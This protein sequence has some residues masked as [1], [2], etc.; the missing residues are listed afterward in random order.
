M[1]INTV[2]DLYY[3]IYTNIQ[4]I[5]FSDT[6]TTNWD[7]ENM[8][9]TPLRIT[10]NWNRNTYTTPFFLPYRSNEQKITILSASLL[11]TIY[12]EEEDVTDY[13][14]TTAGPYHNFFMNPIL[15]RDIVPCSKYEFDKLM[16]MIVMD[17]ELLTLTYDNFD[18]PVL[19]HYGLEWGK[20]L[21]TLQDKIIKRL[22]YLNLS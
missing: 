13:I 8:L 14:L 18:Q 6:I 20:Y 1:F 15:I 5:L 2:F 22:E 17:G 11:T 3:K 16:I 10:Y 21:P 4:D 19:F 9:S 7:S 12:N